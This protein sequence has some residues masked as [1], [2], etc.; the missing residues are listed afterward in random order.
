LRL[1]RD[2]ALP[3]VA[4][5]LDSDDDEVCGEAALAL[6]SSRLPEALATLK[7][8]CKRP[9]D[10]NRKQVFLRGISVSRLPDAIEFLLDLLNSGRA[11]EPA[12]ALDAL[13]LHRDSADIKRMVEEAI[14]RK[15]DDALHAQ[16]R[17]LFMSGL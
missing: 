6:G 14:L 9:R 2:G 4:E 10:W 15:G 12:Q 17:G 16:F 7:Q 13:A 1:E 5:F 3:F 8:A 11:G